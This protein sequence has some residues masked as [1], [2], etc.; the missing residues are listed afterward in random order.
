MLMGVP[1]LSQ[2]QREQIEL[3]P[4]LYNHFGK[5]RES[6]AS[7]TN[8]KHGTC[9]TCCSTQS[10][11]ALAELDEFQ[12]GHLATGVHESIHDRYRQIS[13]ETDGNCRSSSDIGL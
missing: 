13:M 3:I 11:L 4:V 8:Q 10:M 2:L 7:E 6:M 5:S 1:L 12:A 9:S